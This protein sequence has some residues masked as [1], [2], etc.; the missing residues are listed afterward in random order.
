MNE[1]YDF[2]IDTQFL[3]EFDG[4]KNHHKSLLFLLGYHV[5]LAPDYTTVTKCLKK[6]RICLMEYPTNILS[7]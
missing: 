5:P 6:R 3:K 1:I 4:I 7:L 2:L